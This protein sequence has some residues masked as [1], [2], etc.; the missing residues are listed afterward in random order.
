MSDEP[1]GTP[2]GQNNLH[3]GVER[4]V[5]P[6]NDPSAA[7]QKPDEERPKEDNLPET[8]DEPSPEVQQELA[9]AS[10]NLVEPASV[11][12]NQEKEE[13]SEEPPPPKPPEPPKVQSTRAAS[14]PK[15]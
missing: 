4:Y 2:P 14:K 1:N 3:A 15:E 12:E 5:D 7:A 10:K 8:A 6:K 11:E 13:E 9:D